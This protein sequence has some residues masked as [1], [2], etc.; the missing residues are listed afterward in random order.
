MGS[1]GI[2]TIVFNSCPTIAA[3][4]FAD[5]PPGTMIF[6]VSHKD[7]GW[8]AVINDPTQFTRW[9]AVDAEERAAW[10]AAHPD[11]RRPLGKHLIS[12]QYVRYNDY[13]PG[14]LLLVR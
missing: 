5:L 2:E 1:T 7:E 13:D 14:F 9:V 4:A 10:H 6:L 3:D 11:E 8:Q 12:G